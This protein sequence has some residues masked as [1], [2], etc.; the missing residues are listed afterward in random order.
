LKAACRHGILERISLAES[1]DSVL[2][3][4]PDERHQFVIWINKLQADYGDVPGEALDQLAADVWDQDDRNA[5]PLIQ[6]VALW[7]VDLG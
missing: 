5:L 7:L 2:A 6:R 4:S 1:K 3:L